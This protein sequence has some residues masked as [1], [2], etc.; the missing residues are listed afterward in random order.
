MAV[1]GTFLFL[2]LGNGAVFAALAMALVVTYR[3]SASSSF[4]N[5]HPDSFCSW[6]RVRG[7]PVVQGNR[8][9]EVRGTLRKAAN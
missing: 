5:P 8:R 4:A 3:S 2:G 1:Y 7:P 9:E 6:M